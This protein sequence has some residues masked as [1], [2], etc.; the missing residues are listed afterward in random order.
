MPY[1][2]LT[3]ALA[4]S[5]AL[6]VL[7]LSSV[8]TGRPSVA[9]A[10]GTLLVVVATLAGYRHWLLTRKPTAETRKPVDRLTRAD[11]ETFPVW[12]FLYEEDRYDETYVKPVPEQIIYSHRQCVLA[13]NY[14]TAAGGLYIGSIGLSTSTSEFRDPVVSFTETKWRELTAPG[15]EIYCLPEH[16]DQL[17]QLFERD[18]AKHLA[19]LEAAFGAPLEGVF[20][21]RWRLLADPAN[22][23]GI[24][25]GELVYPEP[26]GYHPKD[27]TPP[28]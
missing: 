4:T 8:A 19:R 6:A 2:G 14:T 28:A 25:E 13:A 23:D 24:K 12:E 16:V 1:T 22:W 3:V 5:G 26:V 11:L 17:P 9:I 18:F 7:A 10:A 27:V 21:I 20:P 15:G